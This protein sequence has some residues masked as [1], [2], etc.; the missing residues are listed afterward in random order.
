LIQI[1]I[2]DAIYDVLVA[3][4]PEKWRNGL[5][6]HLFLADNEGMLF[7]F[8]D[9]QT[10]AMHTMGMQFPIDI[11]WIADEMVVG[12]DENLCPSVPALLPSLLSASPCPVRYA[13]E[14]KA[15]EVA[16]HKIRK[17]S[18][19]AVLAEDSLALSK[20]ISKAN[21]TY[22]F[23][24]WMAKQDGG[25]G[26]AS[27]AESS[28]PGFF[29][30]TFG[31][32]RKKNKRV[33][34]KE[35]S[36]I[37]SECL[38]N[39]NCGIACDCDH[40]C[41]CPDASL[42]SSGKEVVFE[43]SDLDFL[44]AYQLKKNEAPP[45][46]GLIPKKVPVHLPSGEISPATRWV[47]PEHSTQGE[48]ATQGKGALSPDFQD[49]DRE[50]K[51]DMWR[52]AEEK[53]DSGPLG[54]TIASEDLDLPEKVIAKYW[55]VW[56]YEANTLDY[57][58]MQLVAIQEFGNEFGEESTGGH[59]PLLATLR[60]NPAIRRLSTVENRM[61]KTGETTKKYLRGEYR[62]AQAFLE[63]Q[64]IDMLPLSR[65]IV[66]DRIGQEVTPSIRGMEIGDVRE[67]ELKS[68]PISAW[69]T[70]SRVASQFA[71]GADSG[72]DRPGRAPERG[73]VIE[74]M[75]PRSQIH[76][77]SM[78]SPMLSEVTVLRGAGKAR[79]RRVK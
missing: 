3:D 11:V 63:E 30:P 58:A 9:L 5:L 19:V 42:F 25:E 14:L 10:R 36:I 57:V 29:T 65:G 55:S 28:D 75:V 46:P 23:L 8:D 51:M 20:S 44:L 56:Q 52:K 1:R 31:Q 2:G 39:C 34:A 16:K 66:M 33:L 79:I 17:G 68:S 74:A 77:L 38:A 37:C 76:S 62:R 7:I 24:N 12:V 35:E 48:D 54:L 60:D 78:G 53:F 40:D 72:S 71:T 47:R 59:D 21:C 61:K 18:Q 22:V 13:V 43:K 69:T 45:R 26:G 67:I 41:I 6:G 70:S 15:G 32:H 73:F 49:W 64:N 50:K 4:T 27:Y